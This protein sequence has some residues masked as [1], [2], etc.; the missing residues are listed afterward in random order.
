[1]AKV[2]I[3]SQ[4]EDGV[5]LY[6]IRGFTLIELI[7]IITI[8]A[9]LLG[10]GIPAYVSWIPDMNLRS[11]ISNIKFDIELAKSTAI[12]ENTSCA[13]VFDTSTDPDSYTVFIDNVTTN[14]VRDG[15]E[16]L[17]KSVD[18]PK[19]VAMI[20]ADT[21]FDGQPAVGFNSRGLPYTYNTGTSQTEDLAG[22]GF[23]TLENTKNNY[24]RLRVTI[25]GV[26]TIQRSTDGSTWEDD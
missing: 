26:A 14:L 4:R 12:K 3:G 19:N 16:S 15:G 8:L 20:A 6:S 22:D 10:V 7:T 13:L 24:K 1:M 25:V 23:V 17:I 2:P 21:D 11:A 9:V 18:I 5:Y